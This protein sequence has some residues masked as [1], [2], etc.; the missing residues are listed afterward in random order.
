MQDPKHPIP[1]WVTRGKSIRQLIK[2]LQTFDDQDMEVRISVDYG[3]SHACISLVEKH[4][5]SFCLLV[6]AESYYKGAWQTFMDTPSDEQ[7][8]SQV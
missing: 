1:A 4:K 6:G 7:P 2:E 5:E 3:D 8:D